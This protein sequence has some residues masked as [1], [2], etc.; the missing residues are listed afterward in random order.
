MISCFSSKLPNYSNLEFQEMAKKGDPSAYVVVPKGLTEVLVDCNEYTP[1]C[2]YGYQVVIKN[3]RMVA[4]YYEDQAKALK[5]AKRIRGYISRN[6]VL[7]EVT[8]EP[9]LE[10]FVVKHLDAKKAED[11]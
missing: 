2:R 1:R 8:G 5:A 6:W 4:L 7:D 3:V 9:V 10:R 11:L